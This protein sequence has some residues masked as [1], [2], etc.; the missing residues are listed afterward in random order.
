MNKRIFEKIFN[1][2]SLI[3]VNIAIII[4]VELTGKFF[5]STGLIH[6]LAVL[7]VLLAVVRIYAYYNSYDQYLQKFIKYCVAALQVFALVHTL[8]F[9]SLFLL[10][11]N[12]EAVT[13][14]CANLTLISMVLIIIGADFFLKQYD[15]RSA[16][17]IYALALSVA[18]LAVFSLLFAFKGEAFAAR[19][20]GLDELVYFPLII[21]FCVF[22]VAKIARIQAHV[23]I[24]KRFVIF[25]AAS[26]ILICGS[27]LMDLFSEYFQ[28]IL[29]SAEFQVEYFSHFIYYA[30]L[31]LF[32]LAFREWSNL[33][34]LYQEAEKLE[35]ES[36]KTGS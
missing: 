26:L 8:E 19:M 15:K 17:L 7:F 3:F 36:V 33:G 5:F 29:K 9:V 12:E 10:R 22:S 35:R 21:F 13:A 1:P 23:S 6:L 16:G 25:L 20:E 30:A 28:T 11:I 32:F 24:S 31:S 27:A 34:G 2:Y 4:V 14:I 18:L